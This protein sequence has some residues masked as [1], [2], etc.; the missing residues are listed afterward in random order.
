MIWNKDEPIEVTTIRNKIL[1]NFNELIFIEDGHKYFLRNEELMSVSH[2]THQY[3]PP[4]DTNTVAENYA[5]KHGFT[6]EYWIEKWHYNN[7]RATTSGTLTHEFGESMF[8]FRLGHKEFVLDSCKRKMAENYLLPTHGKEEAIVKFYENLHPSLYPVLAET[9][10]YTSANPEIIKYNTNYAGTFDILFYYKDAKDDSK[11]GLVIFD[12]KTNEDLYSEY[13]RNV[14]QTFYKPFED[15]ID[16][17][18]SAYILQLS[19]Y[20]IPLEDMG[21]KVIGRRI[22]WLKSNGTYELIKLD[23]KTNEIRE[24]LRLP[25]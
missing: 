7:I 20:Q 10:V 21:L 3:K 6:K 24:I 1:D 19:C 5:K 9:K 12:F 15:L 17:S 2:F 22:V 8:Y 23:D 16:E 4:F 11:S 13:S 25:K 18:L 14:N